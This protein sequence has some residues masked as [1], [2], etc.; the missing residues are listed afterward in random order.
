MIDGSEGNLSQLTIAQD[1]E[2]GDYTRLTRFNSGYST[3]KVGPLLGKV[4]GGQDS[5]DL[6]L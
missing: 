2:S 6:K 5:V 3:E 1:P 4:R